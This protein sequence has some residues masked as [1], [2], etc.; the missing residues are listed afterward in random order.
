MLNHITIFL[1]INITVIIIFFTS[2]RNVIKTNIRSRFSRLI[3]YS[4]I[5]Y[6][7]IFTPRIIGIRSRFSRL[8]RFIC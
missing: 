5:L 7:I 4:N 1:I 8:S 3:I 6:F 2:V